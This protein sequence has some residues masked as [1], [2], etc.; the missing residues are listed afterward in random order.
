MAERRKKA[1]TPEPIPG[2]ESVTVQ[3]FKSIRDELTLEFRPLTVLCG[4]NS[5]GKTSIMQPLLMMKQTL[6]SPVDPGPLL[7]RGAHVEFRNLDEFFARRQNRFHVGLTVTLLETI[8][9][10]EGTYQSR[11]SRLV[12]TPITLTSYFKRGIKTL[13]LEGSS[14]RLPEGSFHLKPGGTPGED[15]Q[16]FLRDSQNILWKMLGPPAVASRE[17]FYVEAYP[18]DLAERVSSPITKILHLPGLRGVPERAYGL[19]AV[20]EVFPG[21]FAAYTASVLLEWI[22]RAKPQAKAA[23]EDLE[24]LGLTARLGLREIDATQVEVRVGR[25]LSSGS[26]DL[27]NIADVGIGVSQVLPV[28]VALHAAEPGTI[29]YIEQ[30]E[31]HLHPRAQ[32]ALA[33]LLVAAAKRKVR[34]VVETHSDL[35]LLGIQ[36]LVAEGEIDPEDVGLQWFHRDDEGVTRMERAELQPDGSFG[37][38]PEDFGDTRMDAEVRFI[39]AY[40]K[41]Q[42]SKRRRKP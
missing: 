9:E 34:V 25:L 20:G 31:L 16:K 23:Q 32:Q 37:E 36:T 38:W 5:S 22:S 42:T 10:G 41:R 19:F 30:P 17:R 33:K 18:V 11:K 28:V 6:E 21:S 39:A 13:E 8:F 14:W 27:V 29:V 12:A 24:A 35:L 4:A 40:E 3:G 26:D 2:I 7:L 15:F 1:A